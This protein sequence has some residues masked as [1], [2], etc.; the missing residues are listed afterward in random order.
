MDKADEKN[1]DQQN[2]AVKKQE[3]KVTIAEVLDMARLSQFQEQ[4]ERV[5]FGPESD[6]F[7]LL[8]DGDFESRMKDV[9]LKP[10]H[11]ARMNRTK[12]LLHE[13]YLQSKAAA[14]IITDR[15]KKKRL[16]ESQQESQQE[17][18][19]ESKQENVGTLDPD[20]VKMLVSEN[21]NTI[22]EG[23]TRIRKLLSAERNP[24]IQEAINSRIV[25]RLIELLSAADD[26]VAFEAAWALT[27]IVSGTSAHV[28]AVVEAG[29]VPQLVELLDSTN[30]DIADQAIWAL[31]NI[32]GDSTNFR[33]CVLDAEALPGIIR[34]MK[35]F[36]TNS[37]AI[38]NATWAVSN[39]CRGKPPPDFSVVRVAIP[40]LA[41]LLT[42]KDEEVVVDACWALSYLS[43]DNTSDNKKIGAI[44]KSGVQKDLV[45][46]LDSKDRGLVVVPAL[47]TIGN[48]VSGNDLQTQSVLNCGV[49]SRLPPLLKNN[50]KVIRKE[51]L[52]TISNI[53]AG[54]RKQIKQT[55]DKGIITCVL[56]CMEENHNDKDILKEA[57]WVLQNAAAGSDSNMRDY[58]CKVGCGDALCEIIVSC[59]EDGNLLAIVLGG[60]KELPQLMDQISENQKKS[61][62]NLRNHPNTKVCSLAAEILG[63]DAR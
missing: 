34:K 35:N 50:R 30:D 51:A 40:V 63:D 2:N 1:K 21:E 28:T 55:L 56:Q 46:L 62:R 26:R 32:S 49:L 22:R 17:S 14:E 10:G 39:L 18:E 12:Q 4:F 36:K 48:I 38:R 61:I 13:T 3:P 23:V 5:G 31:G 45:R 29:A 42:S 52:W 57:A 44:V 33:D 9:G 59:R 11:R 6:A 47:R 25:P 24:P 54:D 58:L 41:G 37:S 20:V 15:N 53:V 7:Q 19:P 60:I 16:K 8:Y 27:N 43:D